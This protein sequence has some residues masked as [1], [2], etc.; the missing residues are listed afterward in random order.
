MKINEH[1]SG[2]PVNAGSPAKKSGSAGPDFKQLLQGELETA[3]ASDPPQAGGSV[4]SAAPVAASVRM[5][6]LTVTE[7]AMDTL[8]GFARALENTRLSADALEPFVSSLEEE[9]M[10]LLAVK[11]QLPVDDSLAQVLERVATITY[12]EAAKFRRGDYHA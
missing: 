2:L 12:L 6:G 5:E 11:N 9:T 10:A 1:F 4:H 3:A 8:Q 7:Q